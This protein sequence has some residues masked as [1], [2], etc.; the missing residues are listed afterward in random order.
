MICCLRD[1]AGLAARAVLLVAVLMSMLPV[2]RAA[3]QTATQPL[4]MQQV[5]QI[6]KQLQ[7]APANNA[8][9]PPAG[10]A[11]ARTENS[12]QVSAELAA[13]GTELKKLTAAFDAAKN[14]DV[15]LSE[16][17]V[18]VDALAKQILTT[19]AATRPRLEEI[20]NR[21]TEL[22]APPAEG[23]PPE[24]EAVTAERQRLMA[25]RNDINALTGEAENLSI[26]A[27]RLSNTITATRRTL[28]SRALFGVTQISG[29]MFSTA[30]DAFQ[31]EMQTLGRSLTSWLSFSWTYKR[32][33]LL[34]AIFLSLCSALV[35]LAGSYRLFASIFRRDPD[36]DDPSYFRR[37]S[38]AFWSTMLPTL[39]VAAFAVTSYL[40]LDGFNVLRS[41]ISPLVSSLL[42]TIVAVLFVATRWRRRCWRRAMAAGV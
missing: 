9:A 33:P 1:R 12:A 23:Q 40:C 41:D 29:E 28:F 27:T 38:V 20:K 7:Q 21:L 30:A 16:L 14:D 8:A 22:G 15:A 13:E 6:Q 35:F 5:Q 19:S 42:G 34:G 2:G 3:A 25:E 32:M 26:S 36:D 37:L 39:S 11:A 18:S 4:P 17:K 24:A 10:D 31:V